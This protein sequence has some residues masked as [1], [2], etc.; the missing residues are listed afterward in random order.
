MTKELFLP[1]GKPP[2]GMWRRL[3]QALGCLGGVLLATWFVD[4]RYFMRALG[5]D[6]AVVAGVA[7]GVCWVAS[8]LALGVTFIGAFAGQAVAGALGGIVFRTGVPLT[9]MAVG[10][11]VPWLATNG[12]AGRVV[13][14]FLVSLTAETI[15]VVWIARRSWNIRFWR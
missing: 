4:A 15:L 13:V 1:G 6:E 8:V 14:Y 10:S 9:A 12:F 7:A 3:L 2:A 5:P 11:Q